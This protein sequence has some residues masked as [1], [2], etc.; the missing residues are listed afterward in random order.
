MAG[1]T[2]CARSSTHLQLQNDDL[3]S[4]SHKATMAVTSPGIC[5]CENDLWI[6]P[7]TVYIDAKGRGGKQL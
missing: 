4:T 2:T 6:H 3:T 5:P 1:K 7:V